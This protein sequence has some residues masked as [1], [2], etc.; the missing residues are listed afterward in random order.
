MRAVT[1]AGRP[2]AGP[3]PVSRYVEHSMG[4]PISLG[5]HA[6]DA[7]ARD[8]WADTMAVLREVDRV[9]STYRPDSFISRLGRGEIDLADCPP[10]VAEVMRL[11]AEADEQFQGTFANGSRPTDSRCSTRAGW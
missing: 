8:A 2:D 4:M 7:L 9:F 3:A 6:A 10:E 1:S 5:R 11:G